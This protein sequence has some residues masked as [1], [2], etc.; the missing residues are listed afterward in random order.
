MTSSSPAYDH[1]A[2]IEM[3]SRLKLTAIRD[4]STAC[5]TTP[6]GAS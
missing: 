5:S 1:D 6:R 4:H 2:L 3:L